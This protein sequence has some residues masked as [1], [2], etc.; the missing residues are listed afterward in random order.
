M[1]R[2]E[3]FPKVSLTKSLPGSSHASLQWFPVRQSGSSGVIHDNFHAADKHTNVDYEY[4]GIA[5]HACERSVVGTAE[6]WRLCL[7]CGSLS[8]RVI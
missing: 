4:Q 8:F 7:C 6:A 2:K 3:S 1:D 5:S